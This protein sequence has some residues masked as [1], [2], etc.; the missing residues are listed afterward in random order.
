[1]MAFNKD[2][3]INRTVKIS[4]CCNAHTRSFYVCSYCDNFLSKQEIVEK[5]AYKEIHKGVYR[6]IVY[7]PRTRKLLIEKIK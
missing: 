1:M 5:P 6:E 2:S 4:L 3:N 7:V